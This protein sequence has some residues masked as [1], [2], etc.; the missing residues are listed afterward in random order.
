VTRFKKALLILFCA[1]SGTSSLFP[2]KGSI[3]KQRDVAEIKIQKKNFHLYL[4]IGQ[5]NMAGRGIIEPQDTIGNER[6]LRLNRNGDWD[7]AKEPLQFDKSFAG[8]GPG[9]AFAR[10]MLIAE[11]DSVVIGLIPCAAGGSGIDVWLKDLFWEETKSTPYNN[12]LLRTKLAMKEGVLK[13]VL[14]H[15]GEADCHTKDI[16]S[17]KDKLITLIQKIRQ[18]LT[19]SDL[20]FIVGELPEF[21]PCSS[22]FN[23]ILYDIKACLDNYDVASGIGLTSNPDGIHLDAV[24]ARKLGIRYAEKM[25]RIDY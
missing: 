14:W 20:P 16:D 11:N 19:I 18:E 1:L 7:I 25:N 4:L 10:E 2:Q 8:V 24:S 13:G 15:Q 22:N 23:P 17:Y 3:P 5:S 9:L 6:I 21:N 12:A